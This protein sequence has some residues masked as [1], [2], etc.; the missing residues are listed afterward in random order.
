MRDTDEPGQGPDTPRKEDGIADQCRISVDISKK[1]L[2]WPLWVVDLNAGPG[3]LHRIDHPGSP[4]V[5]LNVLCEKK[6]WFRAFFVEKDPRWA[7]ELKERLGPLPMPERSTWEVRC[8][9]NAEFLPWLAPV[10]AAQENPQHAMG[11]VLCDPN[12]IRDGGWPLPQLAQFHSAFPKFDCLMNLNA[13]VLLR[14]E[15]EKRRHGDGSRWADWPNLVEWLPRFGAGREWYIRSPPRTNRD[16]FVQL[17]GRTHKRGH[18]HHY[19]GWFPVRSREGRWILEN[20]RP[21][22]DSFGQG[23]LFEE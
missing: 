8:Q 3:W 17:V 14:G 22:P 18:D 15:G 7:T 6:R 19:K 16:F 10:I 12:A 9:N 23:L 2:D 5:L 1:L 21:L 20:L 11:L 4:L 13:S